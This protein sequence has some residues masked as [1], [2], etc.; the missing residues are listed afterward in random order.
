MICNFRYRYQLSSENLLNVS[1]YSAAK[2]PALKFIF[3]NFS[4]NKICCVLTSEDFVFNCLRNAKLYW[5]FHADVLLNELRSVCANDVRFDR[6]HPLFVDFVV[7]AEHAGLAFKK[8]LKV[9]LH[10]M[11]I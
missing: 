7:P 10:W 6:K 2:W 3:L 1:A 11:Q 9:K 4:S 8:E 5:C